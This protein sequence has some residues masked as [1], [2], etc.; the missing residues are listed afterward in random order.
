MNRYLLAPLGP[1]GDRRYR[2]A[3][4]D[5]LLDQPVEQAP[6][7]AGNAD[8]LIVDGTFLQKPELRGSWD[9]VIF[10]EV[11][12]ET[13]ISRG[14]KR[15]AKLL[16]GEKV[17]EAMQRSRYQAAFKIYDEKC[18]PLRHAD[19]VIDNSQVEALVLRKG[20]AGPKSE[21]RA[22]NQKNDN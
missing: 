2:T 1:K 11:A 9:V 15:D 10:L 5:L 18:E 8:I 7:L 16:G 6:A 21:H 3:T 4:F 19:I 14:A 12:E 13:A 17:A 20:L 22:A